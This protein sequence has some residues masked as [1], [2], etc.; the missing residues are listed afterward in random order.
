M[1]LFSYRFWNDKRRV[2]RMSPHDKI[3]LSHSAPNV[4][5]ML[6]PTDRGQPNR[7]NKWYKIPRKAHQ[8][9][10]RVRGIDWNKKKNT[11]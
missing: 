4:G 8:L 5:C 2:N 7:F 9:Y 6:D 11:K 10:W 1:P 3:K